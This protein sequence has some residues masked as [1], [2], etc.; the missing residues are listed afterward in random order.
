M[1]RKTKWFS[2]VLLVGVVLV[3]AMALFSGAKDF[4][5]DKNRVT[6]ITFN[7]HNNTLS[8]S[9]ILPDQATADTPVALLV[10]GD[11]A[12]DRYAESNLLP[13]IH[14]LL[15][16]NIGVFTWDKPGVGK[17]TGSWLQQSMNDRSDEVLAA[18]DTLQ[19]KIK[20]P[21]KKLG[22]IGY[23][24]AGWVVPLVASKT[25]LS[26][27][28]IIGGAVN[29]R[30]QQIYQLRSKLLQEGVDA[31][32]ITLQTQAL[33]KKNDTDF[34]D[35]NT[36]TAGSHP[37]M[38]PDRFQFLVHNYSNDVTPYLSKMTGPVLALWGSKDLN[39]DPKVNAQ[40]YQDNLDESSHQEVGI[41][42]NA[43]HS[44]LRA[45]LFNYQTR[46]EW[47]IWKKAYFYL[48]G[49]DAYASRSLSTIS[50]WIHKI[51]EQES[52]AK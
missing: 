38:N 51:V 27:S 50:I 28:V 32:Q 26:F 39:A 21:I 19:K 20:H 18:I 30:N 8:G 43:T 11:G 36:A 4:Y 5:I 52:I 3:L 48:L 25:S 12:H 45:D 33:L 16:A 23:S 13:L 9:L 7:S 42:R 24:Q 10:Q 15:D 37:D 17:S 29:W 14:S 44:L 46:N 6:E 47:P 40:I 34:S 22:V 1:K 31:D 2:S 49:R 35:P 41:I